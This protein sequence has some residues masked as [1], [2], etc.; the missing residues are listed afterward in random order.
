MPCTQGVGPWTPPPP[1]PVDFKAGKCLALGPNGHRGWPAGATSSHGRMRDSMPR[2]PPYGPG[3]DGH[4]PVAGGGGCPE[5][6]SLWTN[7]GLNN[8]SLRKTSFFLARQFG[9]Q[10]CNWSG[11]NVRIRPRPRLLPT[12]FTAYCPLFE[13]MSAGRPHSQ[14]LVCSLPALSLAISPFTVRSEPLDLWTLSGQTCIPISGQ[15]HIVCADCWP[16][17]PGSGGCDLIKKQTNAN[18]R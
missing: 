14:C 17:A 7:N 12:A 4:P 6:R 9:L 11:C 16:Q 15:P 8:F 2:L 10:G 1:T 13:P 18:Q 3:H 5:L